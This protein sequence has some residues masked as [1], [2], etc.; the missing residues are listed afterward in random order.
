MSSNDQTKFADWVS[1]RLTKETASGQ[2]DERDW[3]SDPW[4]EEEE[5][6]EPSDYE[7]GL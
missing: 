2:E 1:Y 6:L 3:E 5:T 4:L 7:G